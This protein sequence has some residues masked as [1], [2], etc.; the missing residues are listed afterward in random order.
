MT[1]YKKTIGYKRIMRKNLLLSLAIIFLLMSFPFALAEEISIDSDAS[2][3]K[4]ESPKFS[5]ADNELLEP[6][7][8]C[9]VIMSCE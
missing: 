7:S 3:V 9:G 1:R 6:E 5:T 8:G 4:P 2:S